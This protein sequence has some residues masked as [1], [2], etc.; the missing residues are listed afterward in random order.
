M[1]FEDVQQLRQLNLVMVRELGSIRHQ[2]LS[3]ISMLSRS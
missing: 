1:G 3:P 2:R